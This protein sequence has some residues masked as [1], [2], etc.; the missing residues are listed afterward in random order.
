MAVDTATLLASLWVTCGS[1]ETVGLPL[2]CSLQEKHL[3]VAAGLY[4]DAE[5]G[6]LADADCSGD[7]CT[8]P[9]ANEPLN[10]GRP[11]ANELAELGHWQ[12]QRDGSQLG[13]SSYSS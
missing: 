7:S 8:T 2:H 13:H 3:Q 11:S 9:S 5:P 12:Y 1:L 10:C 6:P 4:A